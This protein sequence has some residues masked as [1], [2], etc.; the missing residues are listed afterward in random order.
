MK[1]F[2]VVFKLGCE[3]EFEIKILL[4]SLTNGYIKLRM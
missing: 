2:K 4:E 1:N 3:F